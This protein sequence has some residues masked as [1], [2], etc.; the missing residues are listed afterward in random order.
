MPEKT[1]ASYGTWISPISARTVASAGIG[2]SALPREIQVSESAV[3]WIDFRPGEGGRYVLLRRSWNGDISA[4]TPDNMSVDTKV[5]E[6][7]G[8]AYCLHQDII[9][10]SNGPDQRIY[11]QTLSGEISSITP[12]PPEPGSIRYADG[13]ISPDG[14]Y[15]FCVRERHLEDQVTTNELVIVRTDGSSHPGILAQGSD[16]YA[17]PRFSPDGKWVAWLEWDHPHMPWNETRLMKAEFTPGGLLDA[18]IVAGGNG[19]AIFQPAWSPS[20]RLHFVSDRSGWWNL[21]RHEDHGHVPIAP[22]QAEFGGPMWQLGYSTYTFL[23]NGDIVCCYRKDGIDHLGILPAHRRKLEEVDIPYTSFLS[24]SIQ[25]DGQD[26]VWLLA[27]SFH[28]PPSLVEFDPEARTT[29]LA[30]LSWIPPVPDEMISTPAHISFRGEEGEPVHGYYY[31]PQNSRYSAPP[32][33]KP[34]LILITHGG[35]TSSARPHFQIDIQYWTTRGFAVFDLNYTGSTGYGRTF[36]DRLKGRWGEIDVADAARAAAYLADRG[37]L[38]PGQ[39]LVRGSSAGGLIVLSL[40]SRSDA[41]AAGASYYGVVDATAFAESTHKFE[42]HY[43]DWLIGPY[44]GMEDLYRERFPLAHLDSIASPLIIFQGLD[45][46]IVPPEQAELIV[47]A[48]Q[49]HQLPYAYFTFPGEGH[50]FRR[51]ETVQTALEAELAFYLLVLGIPL[52]EDL[53]P[54]TVHNLP[55]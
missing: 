5:H 55:G 49:D 32:N 25:A 4:I 34:P 37:D 18:T 13:R 21:Y 39:L 45:D 12:A 1:E 2:H 3:Y 22:M 50:G 9:Y 24:P 48:L 19:E 46:H 14:E 7:G 41:F 26:R 47:R 38:N 40:L 6:Y 42:A 30:H 16:F 43:L 20:G 35:P 28:H 51:S 33:E 11:R 54:I 27:G 23:K 8:G 29:R 52:P 15:L 17:S 53:E 44:A 36:R 10:F 31:L